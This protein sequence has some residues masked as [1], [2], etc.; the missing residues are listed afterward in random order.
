MEPAGGAHARPEAVQRFVFGDAFFL[1][2]TAAMPARA[3]DED[4]VNPPTTMAPA[5]ARVCAVVVTFNPPPEFLV[6][7][8]ALRRQVHQVVVIDNSASPV[9]RALLAPL[10]G[11]PGVEVIFNPDNRG[12]AA[13]LNQ[14]RERALAGDF[15]WLGTFDQDSAIPDGFVN[16]LLAGYAAQPERDRI[17]VLAPLFRDRNLRFL[18]SPSGPV[19]GGMADALVSVTATSGNLVST[20]ALRDVGG[21]REDFFIDCVDF[22]FCLRCRRRGW[23]VLEV[24]RVVL[25]HQQGQ[26]QQRRFL[27]KNPRVNDYGAV[28][29]YYQARNRLIVYARL[30]GV[31]LRWTARDAWGYA[32]DF[33]KLLLFCEN[34]PAK[35]RA[36][37]VGVMHALTGRRGRWPS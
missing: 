35:L 28:R 30:A 31:D 33:L 9:T 19:T 32:C 20:R 29:R 23:R 2:V 37:L 26:W 21:F 12:V 8:A 7:L 27:W 24:R 18:Y 6:N 1:C 11:Q 5:D 4:E 25:E 22:E 15:A 14:G 13:A 10:A 34:R 17:A 36:V 16:G 3:R